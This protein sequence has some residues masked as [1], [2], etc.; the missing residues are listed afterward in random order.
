MFVTTQEFKNSSLLLQTGIIIT[1][2]TAASAFVAC[3]ATFGKMN[4]DFTDFSK[5]GL[6][7]FLGIQNLISIISGFNNGT[8]LILGRR[9]PL[10]RH[11]VRGTK[12]FRN[13][14]LANLLFVTIA[15]FHIYNLIKP[16]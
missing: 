2:I 8:F 13:Y 10:I 12:K 9:Q 15:L 1:G 11:E 14:V 3:I 16:A 7:I 5:S 6:L 4:S